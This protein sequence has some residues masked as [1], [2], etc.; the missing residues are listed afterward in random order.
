[1]LPRSDRERDRQVNKQF[2]Y[3]R[4]IHCMGRLWSV[5]WDIRIMV[6][7]QRRWHL[8]G[9][10]E[11]WCRRTSLLTC[12][13]CV[14]R[15]QSHGECGGLRRRQ[16]NGSPKDKTHLPGVKVV[17][18]CDLEDTQKYNSQNAKR[19]IERAYVIV[20]L[21][22]FMREPTEWFQGRNGWIYSLLK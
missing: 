19:H 15:L 3:S 8:S 7:F 4:W 14:I 9:G 18:W 2:Q 12:A 13:L 6:G 17:A 5:R 21:G 22:S 11:E 16:K 1:M 10:P 20:S